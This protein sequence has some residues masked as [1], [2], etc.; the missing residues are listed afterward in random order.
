MPLLI[1]VLARVGAPPPSLVI[2]QS[3]AMRPVPA[4][5]AVAPQFVQSALSFGSYT[6]PSGFMLLSREQ[7]RTIDEVK[8]PMLD[9]S[10]APAGS[11]GSKVIKLR[12]TIGGQG[13]VDSF[14]YYINNR[15]QAEAEANLMAAQLSSGYQQ[16]M[17][18]AN[19]QRYLWAQCRKFTATYVESE[20][21]SVLECEIEFM[22]AD[23]RW[24][25]T[26]V[27]SVDIGG[28]TNPIVTTVGS[29]ITY[30]KYTFNGP[31]AGQP[32]VNP[33]IFAYVPGGVII[34]S[35]AYTMAPTDTV[36][37]DCDPRNRASAVTL[38]GAP[39]LDLLGTGGIYN[40]ANDGAF[41]PYLRPGAGGNAVGGDFY[42]YPAQS[43]V[44]ISYQDAFL[45]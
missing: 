5:V 33:R 22:A 7:P 35:I 41:F 38:N 39:R 42:P 37:F 31:T 9:G 14:G 32:N 23:P 45:F 40:S 11:R 44:A 18:G 12:G 2:P 36:V 24:L 20:N 10:H 6:F 30:P 27:K 16:L 43:P 21:Q 25:S 15:D 3:I 28:Q 26:V 1:P 29:A 8:V 19:P 13:A 17:V 34:V 4:A